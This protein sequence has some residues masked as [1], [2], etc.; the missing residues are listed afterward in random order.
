M[1][2]HT[3]IYKGMLLW[4]TI[5]MLATLIMGIDSLMNN[6]YIL[7][8]LPITS[9][10]CYACYKLIGEEE[11]EVLSLYKWTNKMLNIKE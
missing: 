10:L 9:A 8:V 6:G 1:R 4:V 2:R 5:F 7:I 3:L 11:F